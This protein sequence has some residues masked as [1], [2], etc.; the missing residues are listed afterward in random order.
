MQGMTHLPVVVGNLQLPDAARLKLHKNWAVD[1]AP[2]DQLPLVPPRANSS[3]LLYATIW[4]AESE[5]IGFMEGAHVL[6][7]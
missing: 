1:V 4:S 7:F 2:L 5:F 6:C 3:G